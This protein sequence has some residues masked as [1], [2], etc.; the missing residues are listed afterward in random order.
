MTELPRVL[1]VD[2]EPA[3]CGELSIFLS[4]N[5]YQAF[6]AGSGED[7]LELLRASA[8]HILI[9]DY[10]MPGMNGIE[11]MH[12]A[13]ALIPKLPVIL[14]SGQADVRTVVRALKED[15]ADFLQKPIDL[16]RLLLAMKEAL[17]RIPEKRENVSVQQLGPISVSRAGDRGE[18]TQLHLLRSLDEFSRSKIQQAFVRLLDTHEIQTSVLISLKAVKYINNVGLNLLVEIADQLKKRGHAWVL[19]ELNEPIVAYLKR[20]GYY[21]FFPISLHYGDA[22]LRVT[23]R[24]EPA[25]R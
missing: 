8:P 25:P 14:V 4:R 22:L 16:D 13:R 18:V 23:A 5:R 1:L 15:A 9:T 10:R 24:A 12:A 19:T 17:T 3:A 6:A 7:A 11:L 2:D 21:D 20:L